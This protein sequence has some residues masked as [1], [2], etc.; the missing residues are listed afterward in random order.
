MKLIQ[1]DVIGRIEIPRLEI[2]TIVFEGTGDQ[3]L[4]IGVGHL[5]GSPL[6]GHRGNVVLAAHQRHFFFVPYG[7]IQAGDT[8]ELVTPSGTRRYSVDETTIVT[9]DQTAVLGPVPGAILTLVTCYPFDWFGHAPQRFIVRAH[10][11]K[12]SEASAVEVKEQTPSE[13]ADVMAGVDRL[14]PVHHISRLK[15]DRV[16]RRRSR[17]RACRSGGGRAGSP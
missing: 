14:P 11:I 12:P 4:G 10:E 5:P 13:A 6:P 15:P 7:N 3:V 2:S 9:P 16:A 17:A 1:G 8:I